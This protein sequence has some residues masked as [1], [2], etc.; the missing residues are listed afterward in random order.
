VVAAGAAGVELLASEDLHAA[1]SLA[2]AIDLNAV[3][4]SGIGGIEPQDQ[5]VMRASLCCYGALGVGRLK[6]KIHRK[7]I[8]S[9]FSTNDLVLDA[10][11]IYVLGKGLG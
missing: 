11:E 5:G 1:R 4:P 2:V 7:A 9:L 3:P 8:A 6:M 10:E